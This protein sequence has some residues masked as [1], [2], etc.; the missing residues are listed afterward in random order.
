[1]KI[2]LLKHSQQRTLGLRHSIDSHAAARVYREDE[3]QSGTLF[4]LFVSK[5]TR[6]DL[7]S[8]IFQTRLALLC[9]GPSPY[10]KGRGCA[11]RGIDS[12][13]GFTSNTKL[14]ARITAPGRF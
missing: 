8:A 7:D 13:L 6:L 1:M 14:T 11:Q 5:I 4:E 9:C 10:L 3:Q 12:D 2:S